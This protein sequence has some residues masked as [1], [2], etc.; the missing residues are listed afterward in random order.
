MKLL[1]LMSLW[2]G[3]CAG[4]AAWALPPTPQEDEVRIEELMLAESI[5][6]R[7]THADAA[8]ASADADVPV[9]A[10][11][12]PPA[13]STEAGWLAT[14]RVES[15]TLSFDDLRERIGKRVTITTVNERQHRG[16]VVAVDA[17]EVQLSVRRAGGAATY[18][19]TRDQI[20]RIEPL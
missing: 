10:A 8:A 13:P 7:R 2:A 12:A 6:A 5:A 19:V 15:D 20:Q 3:V 16:T 1:Q 9:I 14:P 18:A 17:R 11:V 4:A